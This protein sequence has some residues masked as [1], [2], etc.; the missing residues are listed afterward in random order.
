MSLNIV[1]FPWQIFYSASVSLATKHDAYIGK[2]E[3][4]LS[5]LFK[6]W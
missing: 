3:G 2:N 5:S 4:F 1:V 6:I